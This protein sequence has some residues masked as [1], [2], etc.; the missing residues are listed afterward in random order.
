L[1]RYCQYLISKGADYPKPSVVDPRFLGRNTDMNIDDPFGNELVFCSQG[2]EV[3]EPCVVPAP[4]WAVV[5]RGRRVGWIAPPAFKEAGACSGPWWPDET[6]ADFLAHVAAPPDD[7]VGVALGGIPAWVR[8][9]PDESG[10]V[11]FW[12]HVNPRARD[13]QGP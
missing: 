9:P 10:I 12:L 2:T 6:A 8:S 7:G 4:R 13:P 3:D 11:S 1:E 5:W